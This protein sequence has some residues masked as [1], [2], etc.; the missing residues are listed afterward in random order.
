MLTHT[1]NGGRQAK[2]SSKKKILKSS[3]YSQ[4]LAGSRMDYKQQ[5][6]FS[7]SLFVNQIDTAKPSSKSTGLIFP[8]MKTL[9]S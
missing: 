2:M 8:Y 1:H 4:G 5:D 3:I 9:E 6:L 7:Q